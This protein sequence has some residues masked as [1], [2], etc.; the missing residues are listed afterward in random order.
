ML[1][2]SAGQKDLAE[3]PICEKNLTRYNLKAHM[4]THTDAVAAHCDLCD[5]DFKQASDYQ[6]HYETFAY[7]HECVKNGNSVF[8]A[9]LAT[10]SFQ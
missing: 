4:A 8:S 10:I 6:Y 1:R 7:E 3:C 9:W 5:K 2:T